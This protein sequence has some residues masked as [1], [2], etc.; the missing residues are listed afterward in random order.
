MELEAH[1]VVNRFKESSSK[2]DKTAN[3]EKGQTGTQ[4]GSAQRPSD[5]L[6]DAQLHATP[7]PRSQ[8]RSFLGLEPARSAAPT[9]LR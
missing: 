8:A 3:V 1:H 9:H 4:L 5:H 7:S 6:R 2:E